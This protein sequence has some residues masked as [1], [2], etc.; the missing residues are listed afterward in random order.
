MRWRLLVGVWGLY[1]SFGLVASCLAPL[2]S[3]VER[4]L[5]IS[6]AAMGGILG[7]WQLVYMVTAIPCGLLLLFGAGW[8]IARKVRRPLALPPAPYDMPRAAS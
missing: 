1:A 4:E 5:D 2:V 8:A 6:H 3:E 7:A